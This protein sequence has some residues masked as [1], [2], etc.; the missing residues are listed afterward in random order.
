MSVGVGYKY[1]G[2]TE[3]EYSIGGSDVSIESVHNHTFGAVFNWKF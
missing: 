2:T 1:L 3:S